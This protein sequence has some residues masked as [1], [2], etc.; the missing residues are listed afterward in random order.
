MTA[1][2]TC[3]VDLTL[4]LCAPRA[5]RRLVDL[6]LRQW[7]VQDQDV[8]DGAAIVVSELVTEALVG[9]DD[10]GPVTVGVELLASRLR[11]WVADPAPAVPAQRSPDDAVGFA[12][13]SRIA[14]HWG[15]EAAG[16]GTRVY[17]DLPVEQAAPT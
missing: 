1:L 3:A 9:G 10:I 5:A 17:A 2:R 15:L 4:D 13:V 7:G 8:L 11:L 12:I 6:V 16:S 14:Q